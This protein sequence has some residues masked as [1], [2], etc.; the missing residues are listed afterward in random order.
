MEGGQVWLALGR[1]GWC[2]RKKKKEWVVEASAASSFM[3]SRRPP[4]SCCPLTPTTRAMKTGDV[5]FGPLLV[6][7]SLTMFWEMD[8]FGLGV[9]CSSSEVQ[10][11]QDRSIVWT[12][13]WFIK[14]AKCIGHMC[15]LCILEARLGTEQ[16]EDGDSQSSRLIC[17][18]QLR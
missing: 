17:R 16:A 15:F 12:L 8:E 13:E 9:C 11:M 5:G 7:Q 18:W 3:L 10:A 14:G 6:F 1:S 2:T 4:R